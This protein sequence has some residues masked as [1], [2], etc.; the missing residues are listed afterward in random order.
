MSLSIGTGSGTGGSVYGE[1]VIDFGNRTIKTTYTGTDINLVSS[2]TPAASNYR[3]RSFNYSVTRD[4]S[5]DNDD[6]KDNNGDMRERQNFGISSNTTGSLNNT[7]ADGN[8]TTTDPGDATGRN[9]SVYSSGSGSHWWFVNTDFQSKSATVTNADTSESGMALVGDFDVK[10]MQYNKDGSGNFT[11]TIE[12]T[13]SADNVVPT[14][15]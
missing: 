15:N 3:T 10:I 12:A 5:A 14:S 9:Q 7:T 1:T 6:Y 2:N 8:N 13:A 11:K 4:Y